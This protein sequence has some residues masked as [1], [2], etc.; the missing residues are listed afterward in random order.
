VV[1][2]QERA[3]ERSFRRLFNRQADATVKRLEGQARAK[4]I[5]E[6]R[7]S[8]G[9]LFDPAF[10]AGQ[11]ADEAAALYEGLATA[12]FTRL[13]DRFGVSFDLEA[14]FAQEFITS[15]ANQLAGQVTTTTYEAITAALAEGVGEGE[16]IPDLAARIREVF[17]EASATRATTIARTEVVGGFGAA[18]RAAITG[19]PS[20]V[21]AAVQWIA[22]RDGRTRAS[23]SAADGQIVSVSAPF[24]VGGSSMLYPGD[25]NGGADECVNCRCAMA[26]LTPEEFEAEAT[27]Y[28]MAPPPPVPIDRARVALAMVQPGEFDEDRFRKA[29]VAA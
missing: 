20:D 3:W 29:L 17:S 28:A 2:Q 8:A 13:S 18:T 25:P 7:A 9:D 12:A 4:K 14:E 22:T 23:H 6:G 15:R 27:L 16:A 10:W 5:S 19:L 1:R 26:A 21:V 24:Q 11:T